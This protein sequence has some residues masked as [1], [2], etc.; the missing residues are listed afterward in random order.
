M[1]S[2]DVALR[3]LDAN[4]H[5]KGLLCE[6]HVVVLKEL[7][8]I[9]SRMPAGEDE[10]L[11]LD[12]LASGVLGRLDINTGDGARR[13]DANVDELRSI[14]D[15]TSE[16]LDALGYSGDDRGKDVGANVRL[17]IPQNIAGRTRLDEGFE[18]KAMGGI[19]V[20]VLSLPSEKVPAPPRPNWILLSGS[21]MRSFRKRSIACERRNAGSPRSM[22]KG[23]RP[24]SASVSAAKRPAHPAP[25]T[26]GR[27]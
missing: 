27:S 10:V 2:V 8:N 20:P 15:D 21:R 11:C 13:V 26:T 16:L 4:A 9:A 6:D 5:G 12:W 23:L 19:L 22:S 17:G 14:T 18:D 25:T 3:M 1:G 7:K 24:A